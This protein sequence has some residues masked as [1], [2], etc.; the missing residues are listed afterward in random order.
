MT[1]KPF[2]AG[3]WILSG[4]YIVMIVLMITADVVY[5]AKEPLGKPG[6]ISQQ[7]GTVTLNWLHG[8]ENSITVSSP[9][10]AETY[11]INRRDV[12]KTID[13][14]VVI[15]SKK[16]SIIVEDG[17]KIRKGGRLTL[18]ELGGGDAIYHILTSPEIHYSIILSLLSCTVAALLSLW[19][20]IPCA[21]VL[22][23][24]S[25]SDGRCSQPR[26]PIASWSY[27]TCKWPFPKVVRPHAAGGQCTQRDFRSCLVDV[28]TTAPST[29]STCTQNFQPCQQPALPP[30]SPASSGYPLVGV[31]GGGN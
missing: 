27:H 23:P 20:A 11:K 10:A 5:L 13:G 7:E 8:G 2:K 17:E 26:A 12:T 19:V 1:D 4:F 31:G 14:E 9:N 15:I 21:T 16:D 22:R 18:N 25:G 29:G 3:L 30:P 24:C 6:I 28:G